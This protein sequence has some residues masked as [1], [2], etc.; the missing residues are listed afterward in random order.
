MENK[1]TL[2][3]YIQQYD[4][5]G[6]T[7]DEL[8]EEIQDLFKEAWNKRENATEGCWVS[9]EDRLPTLPKGVKCQRFLVCSI[10]GEKPTIMLYFAEECTWSINGDDTQKITHWMPLPKPPTEEL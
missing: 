10:S 2:E 4:K 5:D 3:E 9:V 6:F 7:L 8:V 1:T